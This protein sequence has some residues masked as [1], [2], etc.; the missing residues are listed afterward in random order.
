MG[1][2]PAQKT[3]NGGDSQARAAAR[4]STLVIANITKA[5]GLIAFL[6]EVL[7][8]SDA[9]TPV[10]GVCIVCIAGGVISEGVVLA[11]IDR[12]MGRSG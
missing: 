4:G 3:I 12:F 2:Q 1:R 7:I 5:A 8:R 10:L 6:N 9:R 11:I